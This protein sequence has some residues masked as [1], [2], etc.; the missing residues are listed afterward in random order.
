MN[1]LAVSLAAWLATAGVY[2]VLFP[3]CNPNIHIG[4][5]DYRAAG[6]LGDNIRICPLSDGNDLPGHGLFTG[7]TTDFIMSGLFNITH[8][9]SILPFLISISGCKYL[10]INKLAL[11]R[12][13][14]FLEIAFWVLKKAKDMLYFNHYEDFRA[15][16][17]IEALPNCCI[18]SAVG[19]IFPGI[20]RRG[21]S[22]F[23]N[24]V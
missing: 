6:Q 5:S 10:E 9:L 23:R 14:R 17:K 13:K 4:Q 19:I 22:S 2:G 7:L 15:K 3:D 21:L 12:G 20:S 24:I 11:L 16:Y 1:S 18:K 8:Q